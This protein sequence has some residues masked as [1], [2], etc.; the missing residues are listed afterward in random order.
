MGLYWPFTIDDSFINFR[1]AYNLTE[2]NGLTYN[3]GEPPIEGYT[4]FLWT[5]FMTIPHF[6]KI[7]A[8]IFSK[9]AGIIATLGYMFVSFKFVS[10]L[11][12][13]LKGKGRYFP[14]AMVVL[15]LAA[16]Q[17]TAIHAIAGMETALY[18]LLFI[19]FLFTATLFVDKGTK[20]LGILLVLLGLS[21]GLTRPEGNLA[22][23]IGLFVSLIMLS[24][25][26]RLSF[27][28]TILLLYIVP[29]A[30]YFIW[31]YYHYGLFFPLPFYVKVA[32]S[33]GPSGISTVISF[34][35]YLMIPLGFLLLISMKKWISRLF[36][37]LLAVGSQM[38]FFIFPLH[39]MGFDYRFL[40]PNLP[41]ILVM[42]GLGIAV[43]QKWLESWSEPK[44]KWAHSIKAIVLLSISILIPIYL[45]WN[46]PEKVES[47][48]LCASGLKQAH[49]ALGKYLKPLRINGQKPLLAIGD[50]G[51]TPYYSIWPNIDILGLNNAYIATKGKTNPDYTDY[52]LEQEPDVLVLLSREEKKFIPIFSRDKYL[53]DHA[54]LSG[55]ST[56]LKLNFTCDYGYYL[57]VLAAPETKAGNYL[58]KWK[59]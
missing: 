54:L 21:I 45:L 56:L 43:V 14:A 38:I 36:P 40:F 59:P 55:M 46:A 12:K 8:E 41:F 7:D 4:T 31:R 9:A 58:K 35:S 10:Y 33:D 49:V 15:M 28:I 13:F 44:A 53:F 25:G 51:A 2:G 20:R 18:T 17:S 37:A 19:S 1:Y 23:V 48:R 24:K 32:A 39:I 6:L 30:T 57:W 27:F 16:F 11:T 47:K 26:R 50:A 29:G 52:V 3:A 34:I 5:V 22:V 42:A